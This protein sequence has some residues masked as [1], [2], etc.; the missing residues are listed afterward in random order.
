[1]VGGDLPVADPSVGDLG[2]CIS[3][4]QGLDHARLARFLSFPPFTRV[5]PRFPI[6]PSSIEM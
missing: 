3:P 6:P 5:N 1:M 4:P 2:F